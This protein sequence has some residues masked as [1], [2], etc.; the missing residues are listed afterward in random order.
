VRR[1]GESEMS[2]TAKA[3]GMFSDRRLAAKWVLARL[4]IQQRGLHPYPHMPMALR[5][6]SQPA[7]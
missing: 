5:I 3:R 6:V 4:Y 7:E 2:T 1:D